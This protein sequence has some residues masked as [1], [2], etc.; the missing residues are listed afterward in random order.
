MGLWRGNQAGPQRKKN[1]RC[2]D[3]ARSSERALACCTMVGQV[4]HIGRQLAEQPPAGNNRAY[5]SAI[6][7]P[8]D[9]RARAP[10]PHA[11]TEFRSKH[12][13]PQYTMAANLALG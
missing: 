1:R 4:S 7:L 9:A 2:L 13:S 3:L 10:A 8:A 5:L 11:A 6:S 12:H